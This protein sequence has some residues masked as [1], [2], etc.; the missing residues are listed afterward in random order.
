M[1]AVNLNLSLDK[2]FD[3]LKKA[4]PIVISGGVVTGLI[5]FLPTNILNLLHLDS[6][7]EKILTIIGIV[8]LFCLFLTIIVVVQ[9]L[10]L[11][12][13]KRNKAKKAIRNMK[14][15]YKNLSPEQ[16]YIINS[17]LQSEDKTI[18]L[19]M[20]DGNAKYLQD[21][22]FIYLPNQITSFSFADDASLKYLAH[23]WLMNEFVSNPDYFK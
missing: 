1:S 4:S 10:I 11:P 9:T 5:L 16:K 7:S 17:L 23:P 13:I 22:G 2:L 15:K 21:I 19:S 14:A 3:H 12:I 6:I 18:T 20:I 8:F